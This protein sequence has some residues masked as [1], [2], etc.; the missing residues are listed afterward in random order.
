MTEDGDGPF[1]IGDAVT[2]G[3]YGDGFVKNVRK[4]GKHWLIK[5]D[6]DSGERTILGS[7]TFLRLKGET[8]DEKE[9]PKKEPEIYQ[10]LPDVEETPEE[11]SEEETDESGEEEEPEV[12]ETV[13][14]E[15]V[16]PEAEDYGDYEPGTKVKHAI[17]GIGEVKNSR[18]KGE[19]YRLD[20]DFEDGSSKT[21]LSTFVDIHDGEVNEAEAVV[22]E[23]EAIEEDVEAEAIV[24]EPVEAET[25]LDT[26]VVYRR[27][28]EDEEEAETVIDLSKP[29]VQ[30]AEIVDDED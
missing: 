22:V 21:L 27:P 2:H 18:P 14:A 10:K 25:V 8:E 3:A 24:A 19:D 11:V 28:E 17:F 26:D 13:M 9:E 30:D 16:V 7:E 20:I 15:T 4:T 1:I 23:A 12:L 29:E 5:I 6:F